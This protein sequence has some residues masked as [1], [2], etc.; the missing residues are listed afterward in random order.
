MG[1]SDESCSDYISIQVELTAKCSQSLYLLFS[2]LYLY[3][4]VGLE[5]MHICIYCKI[6]IHEQTFHIIDQSQ[7]K[8]NIQVYIAN[9][10]ILQ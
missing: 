9:K 8:H 1:P 5:I 3:E 2:V 6:S 10:G 7:N 4:F